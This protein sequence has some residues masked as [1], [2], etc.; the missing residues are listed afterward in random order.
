MRK[1]AIILLSGG[2]DSATTLAIAK[3]QNYNC[4]ALTFNYGQR[5][6]AEI[7]AA[8]SLAQDMIGNQHKIIDIDLG[9]I[10]G[11]ALTDPSIAMPDKC[12]EHEIPATYVPARNTIFLSIALGYAEVI[13]SHDIFIGINAIDY[14]NYPD[15]RKEYINSFQKMAN[16][17][18]KIGLEGSEI[19]I[20]TPILKLSKAEIIQRGIE[21]KIDFSKTLTCYDPQNQLACGVCLS[22]DIRKRGFENAGVADPTVY[23]I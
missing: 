2:M 23:G 22:C 10:G 15:C 20:H 16:L 7:T 1:K 19:A 11:S 6:S 21:L 9:Q 5:N 12:A 18:I 4:F 3:S 17:A 13:G 14:S 8:K